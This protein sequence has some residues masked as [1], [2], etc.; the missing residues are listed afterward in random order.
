[1]RNGILD[2]LV[3]LAPGDDP[4]MS[5]IGDAVHAVLQAD[6]GVDPCAVRLPPA[7]VFFSERTGPLWDAFVLLDVPT[8][9]DQRGVR[10]GFDS[11]CHMGHAFVAIAARDP[12][13]WG[14]DQEPVPVADEP[15]LSVAFHQGAEIVIVDPGL[16]AGR[17]GEIMSMAVRRAVERNF[18][19]I[20]LD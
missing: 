11:L 15:A 9:V 18:T 4:A 19:G 20:A 13:V 6:P 10:A 7:G 5:V 14:L 17:L 12:E 1:M 16:T 2:V 8:A 3:V